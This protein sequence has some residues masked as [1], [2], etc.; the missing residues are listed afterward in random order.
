LLLV[1]F[2]PA[3]ISIEMLSLAPSTGEV[4]RRVLTKE[5]KCWIEVDTITLRPYWD[6][7]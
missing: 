4:S 3:P 1:S 2:P 7:A 5:A 6:E